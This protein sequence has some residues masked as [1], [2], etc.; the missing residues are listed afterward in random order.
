MVLDCES[1]KAFLATKKALRNN[2]TFAQKISRLR[3]YL[4]FF[5]QYE[6]LCGWPI[7]AQKALFWKTNEPNRRNPQN[8]NQHFH[9]LE[10]AREATKDLFGD[11]YPDTED[12]DLRESLKALRHSLPGSFWRI[13]KTSQ[14]LELSKT[15]SASEMLGVCKTSE[16]VPALTSC[17]LLRERSS[18]DYQEEVISSDDQESDKPENPQNQDVAVTTTECRSM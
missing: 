3:H 18:V 13:G 9:V 11:K 10:E 5:D 4:Q 16:P 1:K 8:L 14:Q 6:S 12:V 2:P 15:S 17:R 7:T